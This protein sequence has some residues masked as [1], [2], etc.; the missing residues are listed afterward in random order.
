MMGAHCIRRQH[1]KERQTGEMQVLQTC[2]KQINED[3]LYEKGKWGETPLAELQQLSTR[4]H[5][6]V[7]LIGKYLQQSGGVVTHFLGPTGTGSSFSYLE[8]DPQ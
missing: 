5:K 4:L 7:G 3:S 8:T 2:H 6:A 1:A